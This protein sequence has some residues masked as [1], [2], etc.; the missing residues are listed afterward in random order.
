MNS[1][2]EYV[3]ES[4]RPKT[5]QAV[6][7][8]ISVDGEAKTVVKPDRASLRIH[9]ESIKHSL[10]ESNSSVERRHKWV[11]EVLTKSSE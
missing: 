2:V 9:I 3:S 4:R 11:S 1:Y 8:M 6:T 7:P 10:S 5:E